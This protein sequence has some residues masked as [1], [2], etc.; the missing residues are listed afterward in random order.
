MSTCS[1]LTTTRHRL[2]PNVQDAFCMLWCLLKISATSNRSQVL[3]ACIL[4]YLCLMLFLPL[5]SA[6]SQTFLGL[7]SQ[8]YQSYF[9]CTFIEIPKL[10][11]KPASESILCPI[12]GGLLNWNFCRYNSG[13]CRGRGWWECCHYQCEVDW[14]GH[15][16]NK[17]WTSCIIVQYGNIVII[18]V[19]TPPRMPHA[20]VTGHYSAWQS[21]L[22]DCMVKVVLCPYCHFIR[23][24]L[25]LTIL[26]VV[27]GGILMICNFCSFT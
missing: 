10:S 18:K 26:A 13:E 20:S 24:S 8:V 12:M 19:P 9:S 16:P 27:L 22:Y 3:D 14:N 5:Y 1:V 25:K 7:R 11:D 23:S 17:S 4:I 2:W 15:I 6:P 21:L